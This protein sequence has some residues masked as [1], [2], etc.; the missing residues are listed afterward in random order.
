VRHHL[1]TVAAAAAAAL[2]AASSTPAVAGEGAA[3]ELLAQ[4]QGRTHAGYSDFGPR[5]LDT[6]LCFLRQESLESPVPGIRERLGDLLRRLD[7]E[8]VVARM[9]EPAG[10][11]PHHPLARVAVDPDGRPALEYALPTWA[12]RARG[13]RAPAEVDRLRDLT[14]AATLHAWEHHVLGH[15]LDVDAPDA[16][17][18]RQE[19]EVWQSMV[20]D[21]LAPGRRAQHFAFSERED[22]ETFY[23]LLCFAA[24]DSRLDHPAWKAFLEWVAAPASGGAA[25]TVCRD[26]ERDRSARL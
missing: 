12:A 9:V 21:V 26:L 16:A 13:R 22:P 20:V 2:A 14:V 18:V 11:D 24:A 8:S 1:L 15:R 10:A 23:G 4:L 17:A 5:P 19:S 25:V 6:I 3:A 7:R